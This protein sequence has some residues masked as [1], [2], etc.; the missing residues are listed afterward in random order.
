MDL[1]DKTKPTKTTKALDD[2]KNK[3]CSR[4]GFFHRLVRFNKLSCVK[5]TMKSPPFWTKI[6][7]CL[8]PLLF[9]DRRLCSTFAI[10]SVNQVI[11]MFCIHSIVPG[12]WSNGQPPSTLYSSKQLWNPPISKCRGNKVT[13]KLNNCWSGCLLCD[14]ID[15]GKQKHC[16]HASLHNVIFFANSFEAHI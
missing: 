4:N 15:T 8:C 7:H 6:S 2:P 16:K 11:P 12:H 14:K 9:S 3:F 13:L 5:I 10:W 1:L